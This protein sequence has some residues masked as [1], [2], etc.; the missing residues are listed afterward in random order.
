MKLSKWCEC[1]N[2][3]KKPNHVTMIM[4]IAFN[5][6]GANITHGSLNYHI[7]LERKQ[8]LKFFRQQ[9]LQ[10][11]KRSKPRRIVSPHH[12][13][14]DWFHLNTTIYYRTACFNKQPA[15]SKASVNLSSSTPQW[16]QL[17]MKQCHCRTHQ[18]KL[19]IQAVLE[20]DIFL[21]TFCKFER[22]VK[23]PFA[24]WN[25]WLL[26]QKYL[27]VVPKNAFHWYAR[28]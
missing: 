22:E 3:C 18:R 19:V 23:V 1:T 25:N 17:P 8:R 5:A 28:C 4:I 14:R 16:L 7:C 10:F 26:R 15:G 12:Y 11:L 27:H 20:D 6:Y 21:L 24:S 2:P 9:T 13:R